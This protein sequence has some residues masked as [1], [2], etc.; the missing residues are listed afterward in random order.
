M[1]LNK[2]EP[3]VYLRPCPFCGSHNIDPEGVATKTSADDDTIISGP[4]C[5]D[6]SA[7]TSVHPSKIVSFGNWNRR[8]LSDSKIS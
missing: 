3:D 1:S 8:E 2:Y 4:A 6:C 7:S 5:D